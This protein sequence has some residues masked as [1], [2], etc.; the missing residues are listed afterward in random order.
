MNV[1]IATIGTRGDVQPYVALGEGMR[2]AGHDVTVCTST[3]YESLVTERGLGYGRLRDDLVALVE[4]PEGRNA[5]AV[6]GGEIYGVRALLALIRRSFEIQRELFRDGW[7][8]VQDADP[9]VI[10]YHPKMAIA[11]HYAERLG[12]PAAIAPLFPVFLPTRA[13]PHPGLPKLQL[14]DRL[15]AV[16]NHA[17]HRLVR[18]GVSAACRWLFASWRRTHGLPPQPWG[19]GVVR[20][21][22]GTRV[23]FLNGWS[24]HVVPDPPDW[25]RRGVQTTGYWFLDRSAEWT[26]PSTLASFLAAGSA[27]VYVGFGSMAGRHPERTTRIVLDAL[28]R[29][30]LRAV[31]ARGWGGIAPEALPASVH[32][33]DQVPH[34]WLFPRVA[35]VV[36]H[37]GAGTTAAGLRAGRPT[38]ICSFFGDQPFWGRRVHDLGAGPAPIPQ[39]KLTAARLTRALRTATESPAVR[40]RA[41]AIG[42][43]IRRENGV[44][45]AVAFIERLSARH[46]ERG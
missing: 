19:T 7:A 9:D 21:D 15:T 8:A 2:R 14:G 12:V 30:G 24:P 41:M 23:P 5:I 45:N 36:H 46:P 39:N 28:R 20:R 1:F 4:T 37:G 25:P 29:T 10:V 3:R 16:Y 40:A 13:Y 6:A 38:V 44:D 22:D 33:L 43:K 26:P 42:R 34:D 31:L 17:T 27:P 35:A 18:G 32:L 11:L